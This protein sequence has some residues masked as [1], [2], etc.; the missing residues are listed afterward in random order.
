[1][2]SA[3][4][5]ITLDEKIVRKLDL[6]VHQKTF[7]NRSKAIQEAVEEKLLRFDR[8]RLIR[9]C[10]KLDPAYEQRMAEEGLSLEVCEWPEY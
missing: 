6:L 9:E 10:G 2:S 7:P 4:I 1:M 5:A 8:G 3:K